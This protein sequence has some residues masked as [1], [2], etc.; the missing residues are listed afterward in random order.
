MLKTTGVVLL[1]NSDHFGSFRPPWAVYAQIYKIAKLPQQLP[2][3]GAFWLLFEAKADAICIIYNKLYGNYIYFIC[4]WT[5][6][7]TPLGH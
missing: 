3:F 1:E 6:F 5:P 2:K 4:I 7:E